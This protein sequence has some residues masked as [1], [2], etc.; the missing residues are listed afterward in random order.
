M[1]NFTVNKLLPNIILSSVPMMDEEF[2]YLP[3]GLKNGRDISHITAQTIL[4]V[5]RTM[6]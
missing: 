6:L 4:S 5:W 2:V 1:I 3:F